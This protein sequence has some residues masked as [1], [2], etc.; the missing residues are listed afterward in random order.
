MVWNKV[1][2]AGREFGI[3]PCGLGA[4]NTLR[5][6]AKMALYGHE[7]SDKI[8]VWEAGLDRYCKMEKGDFI[9]RTA[10][11]RAKAAGLTRTLVGL[12]MVDRGI[13]RD[14]YCCC[15]ESGEVIGF[16][17]SG[18]PS[19]TLC[20]NIALA[21][22]PPA[23]TTLGTPVYVQIRSQKCK[24]QVVATPFYKRPKKAAAPQSAANV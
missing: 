21:Y 8:N 9:G 1:M 15:N 24:A 13:A 11:Q 10:L 5:L 4:R 18:S 17:T 7:I 6:E 3:I 22:V 14:E 16:V 20:K 12:E 23:M 2:E 19:P